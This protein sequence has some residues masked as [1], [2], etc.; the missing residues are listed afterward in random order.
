MKKTF[1]RQPTTCDR[2]QLLDNGK[3]VTLVA[4]VVKSP[5]LYRTWID[6]LFGITPTCLAHAPRMRYI[7]TD[8]RAG[9]GA[10]ADNYEGYVCPTCGL[11]FEE[12]LLGLE[13]A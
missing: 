5:R 11:V 3:S 2:I 8:M 12:H 1:L 9:P 13:D 6:K 7:R 10:F 4:S